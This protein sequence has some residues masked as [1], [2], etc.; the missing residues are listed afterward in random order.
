MPGNGKLWTLRE[1]ADYLRVRP[2]TI[3]R[4]IKLGL[5]PAPRR[6]GRK[7]LWKSATIARAL[8]SAA[9]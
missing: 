3:R 9:K 1:V 4:W 6:I 8:T 2:P 5:F 7:L